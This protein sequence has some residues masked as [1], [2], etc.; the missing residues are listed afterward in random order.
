MAK[1]LIMKKLR[2]EN[3]GELNSKTFKGFVQKMAY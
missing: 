1:E 2:L 3:G